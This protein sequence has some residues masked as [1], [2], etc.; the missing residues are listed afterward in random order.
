MLLSLLFWGEWMNHIDIAEK[1]KVTGDEMK[2]YVAEMEGNTFRPRTAEEVL[3]YVK[4]QEIDS[5]RF[6]FTDLAGSLKMFAI[7]PAELEGAFENGMGFDGSSVDGYE[8]IHESDM[9][10]YPLSETARLIPFRIGHAKAIM[11]FAEIRDAKS[12]EPY[13]D[14]ARNILKRNLE[15]MEKE[16]FTGMNVGPE[17]EYFYLENEESPKPIDKAGYFTL[18][19]VDVGDSIRELTVL[20]LE[21]M[22]VTVEYHHHEVAPSQH[23][24]DLKYCDALS[25]ADRLQTYKWLVKE[26]ARRLGVHATFMPKP[27]TGE[28]GSG[29]HIHLSLWN[30]KKNAFFD[31]DSEHNLSATAEAFVEGVLSRAQELVLVTNPSFNSYRRL[32]PGYEA[33]VYIAWASTNRSALIR[34]PENKQGNEKAT[35][36]EFRFPDPTCN[37]YLAFSILLKAGLDGVKSKSSLRKEQKRDLYKLNAV[38]RE[39]AGI[40][41]LPHD[42]YAAIRAA[43]GS[44]LLSET[45]GESAAKKLVEIKLKEV[46]EYRLTVTPLEIEKGMEL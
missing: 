44:S 7:T 6:W 19:P 34:I 42:L 35:R 36:A 21:S 39:N 9:V 3:T 16:G 25:M 40:P 31:K 37:P 14:D 38:E 46:D 28:N 45:L 27:L 29:M 2:T 24:I 17:A 1:A 15:K 18:N 4:K 41:S 32:V 5:I 26:I 23:E 33:P 22:G 8:R 13:K 30:G 12:G 43:E 20:A 11:M 10:A